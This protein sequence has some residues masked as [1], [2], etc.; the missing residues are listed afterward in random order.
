MMS[1]EARA[2]RDQMRSMEQ[3]RYHLGRGRLARDAGH[4]EAGVAEAR[5]ALRANPHSAWAFALLGQCLARQRQPDLDGAQRALERAQQLE[6]TNGY[7]VRLLLNVLAAQGDIQGRA[8]LL[9]R[10]WWKGAPVERW[11]PDGPPV[12]PGHQADA[13]HRGQ[14]TARPDA[15]DSADPGSRVPSLGTVRESVLAAR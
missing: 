1:A 6:P 10:A 12:R 8:D 9:A 5:M 7:F 13:D 14:V 3:L 15:R 2:M 11:L 4:F